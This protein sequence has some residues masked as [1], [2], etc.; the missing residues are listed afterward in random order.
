MAQQTALVLIAEDTYA[1]VFLE[2]PSETNQLQC[3]TRYTNIININECAKQ[4]WIEGM[5]STSKL[6]ATFPSTL[7]EVVCLLVWL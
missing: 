6:Q 1:S 7:F 2:E 3:L 4:Q 5:L